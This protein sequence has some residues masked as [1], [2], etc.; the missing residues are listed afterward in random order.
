MPPKCSL[1]ISWLDLD[2]RLAEVELGMAG[3]VAERDERFYRAAPGDSCPF[4]LPPTPRRSEPCTSLPGSSALVV[5]TLPAPIGAV[6]G[7]DSPVKVTA[8]SEGTEILILQG[9][10]IGEP[11]AQYGSSS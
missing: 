4:R 10:P 3:R 2:H 7:T 8:G 1:L 11:V 5:R 9:K 6:L